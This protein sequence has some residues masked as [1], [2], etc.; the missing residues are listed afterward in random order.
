MVGWLGEGVGK[1]ASGMSQLVNL[2]VSIAVSLLVNQQVDMSVVLSQ[3]QW[4][5]NNNIYF[6]VVEYTSSSN[7]I[8]TWGMLIPNANEVNLVHM[9]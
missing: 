6:Y 7:K 9:C 5:V 8:Y 2:S 1:W 3:W 4:I